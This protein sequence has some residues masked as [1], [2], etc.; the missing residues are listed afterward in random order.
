MLRHPCPGI[1]NGYQGEAA[2]Q[3]IRTDLVTGKID[4]VCP[5]RDKPAVS[6]RI[7]R[8][9]NEIEDR[10]LELVHV[11]KGSDP[12][13]RRLQ[14]EP[15]IPREGGDQQILETGQDLAYVRVAWRQ[16]LLA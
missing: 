1:G 11:N 16:R 14:V 2:D 4:T 15:T 3:P 5:D 12:S 6:D 7:A 9:D 13:R 10:L 8:I